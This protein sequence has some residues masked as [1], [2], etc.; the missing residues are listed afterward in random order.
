[1]A[2]LLGI[3]AAGASTVLGEVAV[4]RL[5]VLPPAGLVTETGGSSVRFMGFGVVA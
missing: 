4:W 3:R 5:T 2:A 1:M